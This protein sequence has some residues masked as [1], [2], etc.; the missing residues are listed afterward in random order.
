MKSRLFL[1]S[2]ALAVPSAAVGADPEPVTMNGGFQAVSHREIDSGPGRR[3]LVYS[4]LGTLRLGF[5]SGAERAFSAECLG[6]DETG[7]SALAGTGRC[8]WRDADGDALHASLQTNGDRN[9]YTVTGGT[10]KW[11]GAQGDI[12][13]NFAY[14]PAPAGTLLI[15]ETGSGRITPPN[16]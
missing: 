4:V 12:R 3:A 1:C 8:L 15:S 7:G 5:G 6:F 11:S 2:L 9:V 13:T 10:G 14:L 16:R